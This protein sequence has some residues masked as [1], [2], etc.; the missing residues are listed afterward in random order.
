MRL[1][2]RL[3]L[4]SSLA[5]WMGLSPAAA[6][7][8]EPAASAPAEDAAKDELRWRER[9][10]DAKDT[11]NGLYIAG[12]SIGMLGVGFLVAGNL[13]AAKA[14]DVQGCSREGWFDIECD[15]QQ[16]V[17]EAQAHIDDA[18]K[19]SNVGLVTGLIGVGLLVWGARKSDDVVHLKR[20]GVRKGYTVSVEPRP[21]GAR[22]TVA[23]S[24]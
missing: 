6:A 5:L 20:E 7:A 2:P 13:K 3:V 21:D 22:L 17:D 23:R 4:S 12:G 8:E 16:G 9:L 19:I 11:R 18:K 10:R 15:T 14:E 1:S 24:F